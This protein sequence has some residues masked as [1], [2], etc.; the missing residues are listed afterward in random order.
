MNID[1]QHPFNPDSN[2]ITPAANR[3]GLKQGMT[4]RTTSG[5]TGT[6]VKAMRNYNTRE[7]TPVCYE[8]RMTNAAHTVIIYP[9]QISAVRVAVM[10]MVA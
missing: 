10:G 2:A 5:S 1:S 6:I 4:I 7:F 9:R 3:Y 8:V